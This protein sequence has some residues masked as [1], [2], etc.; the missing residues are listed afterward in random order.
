MTAPSCQRGANNCRITGI[1][2]VVGSQGAIYCHDVAHDTLYLVASCPAAFMRRGLRI[3]S[4]AY[5]LDGNTAVDTTLIALENRM[6]TRRC[7]RSLMIGRD[8]DYSISSSS[9]SSPSSSSSVSPSSLSSSPFS[10]SSGVWCPIED[11]VVTGSSRGRG[12]LNRLACAWDVGMESFFDLHRFHI[13]VDLVLMHPVTGRRWVFT[14]DDLRRRP[15]TLQQD[16]ARRQLASCL[17]AGSWRVFATWMSSGDE[18]DIRGERF[19]LWLLATH[20]GWVLAYDP[21]TA[22]MWRAASSFRHLCLYGAL[23]LPIPLRP[24]A[25]PGFLR[26]RGRLGHEDDRS[27]TAGITHIR[28]SSPRDVPSE[29]ITYMAEMGPSPGIVENEDDLQMEEQQG[30]YH[31]QM[32]NNSQEADNENT[33]IWDAL[34]RNALRYGHRWDRLSATRYMGP[35]APQQ[36]T[37]IAAI[38]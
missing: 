35:F 8:W 14:L 28:R 1:V 32:H 33:N 3:W 4:E 27:I 24:E 20:R 19:R 17:P 23:A 9:S 11:I 29:I 18:E 25:D 22:F 38:Y 7:G 26:E 21:D 37:P 10:S 34:F 30:L 31:G 16:A 13:G 5:C 6:P 12:V 2:I 36:H 15:L